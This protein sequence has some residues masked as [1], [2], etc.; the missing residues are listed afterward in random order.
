MRKMIDQEKINK[1]DALFKGMTA[2]EN[3]NVEIGKNLEVDGD[4]TINSADNLKTK[5]GTTFGGIGDSVIINE[6]ENT[7][8]EVYRKMLNAQLIIAVNEQP[9]SNSDRKDFFTM[10]GGNIREYT[11]NTD[12]RKYAIVGGSK[13]YVYSPSSSYWSLVEKKF[14]LKVYE[15]GEVK[16]NERVEKERIKYTSASSQLYFLDY[17][18]FPSYTI[19]ELN[20]TETPK[21]LQCVGSKMSWVDEPTQK[22]YFNHD[23]Q[24]MFNNSPLFLSF[25]TTSNTPIDSV[26]DLKT[27]CGS[28]TR[29]PMS[30]GF[31]GT[32]SVIQFACA[33]LPQENKLQLYS[34]NTATVGGT[35]VL[36]ATGEGNT[37]G[38]ITDDITTL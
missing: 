4:V 32:G 7:T 26:T 27:A 14:S 35:T 21:I 28:R 10:D 12:G 20:A 29:I 8:P 24:I 30:G 36:L 16:R 2:D 1:S 18:G 34:G 25:I 37:L 31:A 9:Y 17:Y 11:D 6:R 15:D 19:K 3:G 22:Q 23:V 33:Y 13:F 5:D 38:T